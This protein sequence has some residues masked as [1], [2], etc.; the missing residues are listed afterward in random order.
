ML[1][2]VLHAADH[3]HNKIMIRT[4]DADGEVLAI[5]HYMSF[6]LR[7]ELGNTTEDQ[8]AEALSEHKSRSLLFF[9][10]FSL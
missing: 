3:G 1:L 7:L 8:I 10:A 2:H 6:V 9:H 4:V 5:S